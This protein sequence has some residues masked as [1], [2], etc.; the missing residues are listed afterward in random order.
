M[1]WC[2]L[3]LLGLFAAPRNPYGADFFSIL[4]PALLLLVSLQWLLLS[5]RFGW[6]IA[7]ICTA[8]LGAITIL[9]SRL[10]WARENP[11]NYVLL[12][13]IA[14]VAQIAILWFL[15]PDKAA[16]SILL[17]ENLAVALVILSGT[18]LA[19]YEG[20]LSLPAS[21]AA[22][23]LFW[24]PLAAM[25]LWINGAIRGWRKPGRIIFICLIAQNS[26]G[27]FDMGVKLHATWMY[28]YAAGFLLAAFVF[29][30]G[31]AGELN[32]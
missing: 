32:K 31:W 15:V 28:G 9:L 10:P 21:P 1:V 12:M 2:S 25:C 27:F 11:A 18:R 3:L 26:I 17:A 24:F 23:S 13:L 7:T 14:M 29:L 6:Q 20:H 4:L 5:S 30:I 16:R 19:P 22:Q 8:F